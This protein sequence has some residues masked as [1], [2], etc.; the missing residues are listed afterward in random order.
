MKKK[1]QKIYEKINKRGYISKITCDRSLGASDLTV[2]AAAH[3]SAKVSIALWK[4]ILLRITTS[5]Y[6]NISH[7]PVTAKRNNRTR[8]LQPAGGAL[9]ALGPAQRT[10]RVEKNRY[11]PSLPFQRF[12][13][14]SRYFNEVFFFLAKPCPRCTLRLGGLQGSDCLHL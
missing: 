7:V 2:L 9:L 13:F 8:S 14:L 5:T 3:A 1:K 6:R 10:A 12:S 11:H 4:S